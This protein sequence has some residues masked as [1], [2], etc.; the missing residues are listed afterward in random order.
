M[1][2]S[3]T[4]VVKFQQ[5]DNYTMTT[6]GIAIDDIKV[7]TNLPKPS[8]I[9]IPYE[10]CQYDWEEYYCAPVTGAVEYDWA[11][12]GTGASISEDGSRYVDVYSTE[13]GYK[14]LQVRVKNECDQWSD[15]KTRSIWIDDCGGPQKSEL[16]IDSLNTITNINSQESDEILIYPNPAN[17]LLNVILPEKIIFIVKI[18]NTLGQVFVNKEISSEIS[19]VNISELPEG[20]YFVSIINDTSVLTVQELVIQR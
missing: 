7:C 11:I 17:N 20:L 6:D 8:Y 5:Y 15:W 10:H 18:T 12:S 14:T 13:I 2:H 9:Y 19:V 3:S 16:M 4:F 1:S